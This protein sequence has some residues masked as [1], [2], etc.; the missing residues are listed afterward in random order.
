MLNI[1]IHYTN[2]YNYDKI[3]EGQFKVNFFHW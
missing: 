2:H 3:K 1:T